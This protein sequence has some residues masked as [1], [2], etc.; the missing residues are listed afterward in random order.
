LAEGSDAART[1][2]QGSEAVVKR[3]PLCGRQF[4]AR[5]LL[6][7]VEVNAVGMM[8][9]EGGFDRPV[10]FFN[11]DCPSCGTSFTVPTEEFAQ[12]IHEKVPAARLEGTR[13][14]EG[15]C[16]HLGDVG[17]CGAQCAS[18]PYRRFL[19]RVLLGTPSTRRRGS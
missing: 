9:E 4:T 1:L 6:A 11:H 12:F 7:D 5:D 2:A 17:E 14:C 19:V 13:A 8:G 18:A 3:C 16:S 10:F 15:H